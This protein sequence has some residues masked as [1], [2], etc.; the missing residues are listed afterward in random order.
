MHRFSL[1]MIVAVF[2]T[3]IVQAASFEDFYQQ[4]KNRLAQEQYSLAIIALDEAQQLAVLPE[5]QAY[6]SGALGL[7]YYRMQ[8]WEQAKVLLQKAT[9]LNVGDELVRTKWLVALADLAVNKGQLEIAK[10]LYEQALLNA[11]NDPALVLAL[12]VGKVD[13]LPL[14]QR[15]L[16]LHSIKDHLSAITNTEAEVRLLINLGIKAYKTGSAGLELAFASFEQARQQ[17]ENFPRLRAEALGQ[18]AQLYEQ[19]SRYSEALNLNGLAIND[20]QKVDAHDLLLEL[21][22]RQGRL[23]RSL[24]H[25]PEATAAYQQAIEHIEAIRQDIPVEYQNGRSSFREMLEPVYLGLVDLLLLQTGQKD[26][27]NKNNLLLQARATVELIKQTELEDFLG[28]RCS[29]HSNKNALLEEID[30]STAIIYPIILP[31]RLEILVSS[32]NEIKQ[33]TQAISAVKLQD[34]SKHLAHSLRISKY[35]IKS[36]SQQLYQWLISPIEP[37]LKQRKIETL[38]IVPDGVLRLIPLAVLHDGKNYLIENYA[39][40]S[41]PGLTLF[42]STSVQKREL[43][44]LLAGMSE[45]GSVIENL[46][47]EFFQATTGHRGGH[48]EDMSEDAIKN[49]KLEMDKL[50]K[51]PVFRQHLKEKLSLPG[52]AEEI[53]NL[54]KELS[55]TVLMNESF[56]VEGFKKQALLEPYSVMHIASHGVFGKTAD[57][58]FIM[59]YDGIINMDALE[60]LLKSD[61]FAKQPVELLTL[62]A[63]QTAEGDDRAPLGLSGIAL[64]AKVRSVLGTLWPVSDQAASVLMTDFYKALSQAN[65]SKAQALQRAQIALIKQKKFE[66][67]NYWSPFILAGNWL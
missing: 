4:G 8:R 28:G 40:A 54:Q 36:T 41:S 29:V 35:D 26:V 45:P 23:Q 34:L 60:Q 20:A 1:L 53:T 18:L 24:Q 3:N 5:Q 31:D 37:W 13:T 67:P 46:P 48:S 63:C 64:K 57:A 2:W 19:E 65:T 27:A 15:L 6:A 58:S 38:V 16:E 66:N 32:G 7:T 17:A 43:K 9:A 62:S 33:F 10:P 49:R 42:D 12:R 61:K 11:K 59:T 47:V 22:W 30:T 21:Q 25:L 56:S 55:S 51:E 39:I 44:V 52:V 14:T 50:L